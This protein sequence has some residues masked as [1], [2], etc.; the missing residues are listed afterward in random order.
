MIILLIL[1]FTLKNRDVLGDTVYHDYKSK[2]FGL[3]Y[4]TF[5]FT[6]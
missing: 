6:V 5:T 4:Y 2:V 1:S 3:T